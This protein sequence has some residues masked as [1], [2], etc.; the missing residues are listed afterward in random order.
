MIAQITNNQKSFS[1]DLQQPIDISIPLTSDG[2]SPTAWYVS[3]IKIEA[4]RTD[5]FTGSVEEGGSVNFR[6]IEFNPH[7]NGT[8]TECVGHISKKVFSVNQVLKKF[9]FLAEL[10]SIEPEQ[11]ENGDAVITLDQVK[12]AKNNTDSEAFIIRTLPNEPSKL[13]RQYSNTNPPYIQAKAMKYLIDC[14][15]KHFLIDTPS[16]D[17]EMDE[18]VLAAHHSFWEYPETT[19]L[20]RTITELIFVPSE[21]KDGLYLLNLQMASFENDASPSKPILYAIL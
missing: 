14:G 2:N 1:V 18:G 3:P 17:R 4:V 10:V 19:N 20:E 11:S 12:Q 16:V 13:Q 8:H 21:V 15:I 9:F 5:Q 6:N 7:G